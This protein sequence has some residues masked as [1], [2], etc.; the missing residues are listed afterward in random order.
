MK[1]IFKF[2]LWHVLGVRNV[3]LLIP[4]SRL[5]TL[6]L[7]VVGATG[8]VGHEMLRV[9]ANS[10]LANAQIML[11]A[12]ERNAGRNQDFRGQSM[13]VK[14][15]ADALNWKPDVV[16]M[17]AGGDVSR[18]WAPVLAKAGAMVIDNSSTWRMD[19]Q[20]PLIVPEIN[21]HLIKEGG[22]IIA[23]PNCSTIQLVM[24]LYPLHLMY[25][26]RRV[27]VSTYQSVTGSGMRALNQMEGERLGQNPEQ[28]YP[29]PIDQNCIPHCDV[30]ESDGYTKE[31][32]KLMNE[33]QKIMGLEAGIISAT[34]VR[35]PVMGGHS[36]SV[37]LRLDKPFE[38]SDIRRIL[39]ETP[40]ITL[41]DQPETL[42]YPMPLY[43]RGKDDVFVGRIR[44][45]ASEPHSLNLWIVSDNLRKGAATNAVQIAERWAS[46]HEAAQVG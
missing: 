25:G 13:P 5:Q 11:V 16:L 42:T 6:K 28:F 45:D 33:P 24:V 8:M 27:V 41:Q 23:N 3:L 36:E 14:T 34:A 39:H 31:E 30:F 18:E 12:S 29:Y 4:M 21:G 35:V 37:N 10:A 38:I 7:A 22:G 26:V 1:G 46:A 20:I 19:P 15:L 32:H 9:L 17:S 40:G 44:R 43:A 2:T